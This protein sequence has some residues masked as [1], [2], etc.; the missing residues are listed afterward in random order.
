MKSVR[1]VYFYLVALI[2]LEVVVWGV[3]GLLR[4][5]FSTGLAFQGADTLSQAL[6]LV[7]VGI[8]IFALHWT[9][10]QRA[11]GESEELVSPIRGTFLY[12]ALLATLL[13]VSQNLLAL[14][15]RAMLQ[16]SGI[17]TY[18]SFVGGNQST[19]DNLIAIALNGIVAVYFFRVL[20]ES[21]KLFAPKDHYGE[22]ARLYGIVWVVYSLFLVLYG[23]QEVIRFIFYQ[24]ANIIGPA[25]KEFFLNGLAMLLIG[26]P[27]W[28]YS[29]N[30]RQKVDQA[31]TQPSVVRL[32]FLFLLSIAGVV[33]VLTMGS[34]VLYQLIL[35]A[36][37][38]AMDAGTLLSRI[39][40]P[41][42]VAV[43]LSVLWFYYGKWFYVEVENRYSGNLGR[44]ILRLRNYLLSLIGIVAV[45]VALVSLSNFVLNVT[46]G[47]M[48]LDDAL[49]STLSGSLAALACALPLWYFIWV[50]LQGEAR[51][52]TELG[53][54]AR[55]SVVRR[56]YLYIAIF[57]AVIAGMVAAISLVNTVLFGLLDH[58]N[59]T[60]I[61]NVLNGITDVSIYGILL[62]YHLS[63][64]KADNAHKR[65]EKLGEASLWPVLIVLEEA[66]PR[67]ASLAADCEKN[68]W[69]HKFCPPSKLTREALSESKVVVIASPSE[70]TS[71]AFRLV[72]E[73]EGY[74]LI[75]PGILPG[76]NWIS[77]AKF[78]EKEFSHTMRSITQGKELRPYQ[79]LTTWQVIAYIFA[80]IFGLQFLLM[81]AAIVLGSIFD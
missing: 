21:E 42:S 5:I 26:T 8:P 81:L 3:I 73:W 55:E 9:W 34:L 18:F 48:I 29:W 44:S 15:N 10:A 32:V 54:E 27:L 2:S 57:A 36:L 40:N 1:R 47:G 6:A 35:W 75:L 60:F 12:A 19:V 39:G 14:V 70:E 23:I 33:S 7:L 45:T 41:F 61:K 20:R 17:N 58:Q 43:S 77:I 80:V 51:Q 11:S 38:S 13:P 30:H 50:P 37:G 25:G 76:F 71:E 78:D 56:A 24:P 59:A 64:L 69:P 74:K 49:R 79:R 46:S 63:C 4:T 22:I 62:A 67:G 65:D 66:D 68:H 53:S 16:A 52:D 31:E 28:V 72:S